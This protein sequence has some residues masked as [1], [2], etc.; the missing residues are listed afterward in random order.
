VDDVE[1]AK[2]REG[3]K[4]PEFPARGYRRLYA[5]QVLQADEGVDFRFLR[6]V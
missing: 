2:R 1:I 4:A 5:D 3:W 6:G